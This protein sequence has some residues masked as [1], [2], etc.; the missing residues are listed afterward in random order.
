MVLAFDGS[1]KI[2]LYVVKMNI[3]YS[4]DN[5]YYIMA[6]T[7]Q[8]MTPN[9]VSLGLKSKFP[10]PQSHTFTFIAHL[11]MSKRNQAYFYFQQKCIF[12]IQIQQQSLC[13]CCTF[14]IRNAVSL[15]FLKSSTSG[16][17]N[18]PTASNFKLKV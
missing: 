5:C 1:L 16:F 9:D 3:L 18:S 11:A 4:Q 13:F 17:Q 15:E 2:I 10:D 6:L 7:L 8:N 12:W 14:K